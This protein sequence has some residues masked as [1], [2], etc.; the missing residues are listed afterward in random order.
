[1]AWNGSGTFL[2]VHNWVADKL[3]SIKI[4]AS[5]MDAE[6]DNY[7]GGLENCLTRDGQTPPTAAIPFNSQQ[8]T[9]LAD[10]TG[11]DHAINLGQLLDVAQGSAFRK[12]ALVNGG[13]D[14][15]Q[16]GTTFA[17]T[18]SRLRT[19][20]CWWAVRASSAT[21]YTVSRATGGAQQ[22]ALKW[23][24][25]NGNASTAIMYLGQSIESTDVTWMGRTIPSMTLSF[26]ALAGST[27]SGGQLTVEVIRGTSTNQ[28][29]LDGFTGASVVG[30]ANCT[31]TT[32][33][34]QFTVAVTLD[35]STAEL[36]VRFSWT[37]TGV[38]GAD[39]SVTIERVQLEFS[40]GGTG[41]STFEQVPFAVTLERCMRYYQKSFT[42]T[43][44][45]AQNIGSA[46]E[47]VMAGVAAG[48]V[49]QGPL[50]VQ[51]TTP[52]RAYTVT[53][54]NPSAANTAPRNFTRSQDC[55]LGA[56][57][58]RQN[59]FYYL[60]TGSASTAAGDYIGVNW[61]A[62]DAVY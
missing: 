21:G 7:K 45:P 40:D 13:F 55:T 4:I 26:N 5:R 30:T 44:A 25:D 24:R 47:F 33:S 8:I 14:V 56:G 34:Q 52:M 48:A 50:Q 27:Y 23:Q 3:A 42:Y 35:A 20:D 12:N 38:A 39:D 41:P 59:G 43:Q 46:S 17:G 36:G 10:G 53:T 62:A 2:R 18:A 22:Y 29:V 32:S 11:P 31:L 60:V 58:N 15:W 51:F 37:P 28:N 9:G 54:Y 1:M 19:A 61:V 57:L 6:F 49:A 16:A